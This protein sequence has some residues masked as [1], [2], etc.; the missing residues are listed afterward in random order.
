MG[1]DMYA[2]ATR[3]PP[4]APVDFKIEKGKAEQFHYWRK[5]PNMHGWM[6]KLYQAKG[7]KEEFNCVNLEITAQDLD[8]LERAIKG[9]HLPDTAGFFFGRSQGDEV[10]DDLAFIAEARQRIKDGWN[11]YYSSWW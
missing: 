10:P 5:H 3:E 9:D 1:L 2:F 7:G 11:I 8:E 6:E 4:G